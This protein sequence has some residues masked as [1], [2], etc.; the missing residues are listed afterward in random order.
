MS[1]IPRQLK[2][3]RSHEWVSVGEDGIVTVGITDHA[4]DL[5][6]DLVYVEVPEAG[7]TVAAGEACGVIE[8]VKAASDLYSPLSGEIV[9]GNEALADSP[10]VV[11]QDP[12]GEGWIFRIKPGDPAEL[13]QLMDAEAYE[14]FAAEDE[15]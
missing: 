7:S 13:E 12:Y 6:G 14:A 1:I 8:S 9:E 10:E 11:N 15:H 2:Y 3:S 5:L 4:Q